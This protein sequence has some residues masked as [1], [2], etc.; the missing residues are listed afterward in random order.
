MRTLLQLVPQFPGSRDGVGDYALNLAHALR[1]FAIETVFV[2]PT[3]A[4]TSELAGFRVIDNGFTATLP[5][6]SADVLLHYV[7][8]AYAARGLPFQLRRWAREIRRE[9]RGRWLTMFHEIYASS[10]PLQSAFWVRPWQ[11]A[12][13]RDLIRLS[14][15][16][17][18]SNAT[19]AGEI[20]RHAPGKPTRVIPVMSN[21]GEPELA[22]FDDRSPHHWA[23]CGG[24][25]LILRSLASLLQLR[26]KIPSWC[27]PHTLHLIGGSDDPAL[28]DLVAR[29]QGAGAGVE[30]LRH[31]NVTADEAS[32]LLQQSCFGWLDYFGAGKVWPGMIFKSGSL[33]ALCAHGVIPVTR[34]IESSNA[35]PSFYI[36]PEEVTLPR[37]EETAAAA[38]KS[39]DWYRQNASARR[40]AEQYAEALA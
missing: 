4:D 2:I 36:T 30:V 1:E 37:S 19:V 26:G 14:D 10:S 8:Y 15:V 23:I 34:H 35:F 21:F 11:V 3:R 6:R 12:I 39:Y 22:G 28:R 31:P 24:T 32:M 7:N 38:R 25:Q 17:F 27:E 9:L 16:C 40:T 29:W 33:A 20:S 18:A 5:L 13:A